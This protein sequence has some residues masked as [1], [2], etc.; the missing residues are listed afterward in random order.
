MRFSCF[1][2]ILGIFSWFFQ[3]N[4][5]VSSKSTWDFIKRKSR[6]VNSPRDFAEKRSC[7]VKSPWDFAELL[8]NHKIC[9]R[10]FENGEIEKPHGDF[11][12]MEKSK[13]RTEIFWKWK[14]QKAARRFSMNAAR[15]HRDAGFAVWH[16][17]DAM[18]ARKPRQSQR[19]ASVS[20]REHKIPSHFAI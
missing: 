4:V 1:G 11:S 17:Y 6:S 18:T 14:N 16:D 7:S 20:I 19:D 3:R 15:S 12:K 8:T 10:F 5:F 13:S 9:R 2:V